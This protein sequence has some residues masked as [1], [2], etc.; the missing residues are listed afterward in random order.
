VWVDVALGGTAPPHALAGIEWCPLLGK[1]AAYESMVFDA[2]TVPASAYIIHW[3][4]PPSDLTGG[5]WVW[6]QETMAGYNGAIF[7]AHFN[8]N[9]GLLRGMRVYSKFRW[10][11]KLRSFVCGS[12]LSTPVQLW[13]PLGT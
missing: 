13:R 1:F 7:H 2:A 3:L 9:N 8:P 4:T 6:S 12:G 10:V 5:T 11:P